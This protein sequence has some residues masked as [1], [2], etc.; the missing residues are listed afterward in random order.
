MNAIN[1]YYGTADA[2][3]VKKIVEDIALAD[4]GRINIVEERAGRRPRG[5]RT[6]S[7]EAPIITLVNTTFIDAI[8]KGACDVHFEPYE[9]QFRIR[10]RIDGDLYEMVSLPLKFRSPVLSRVKIL[11]NMDIAEKRLPQ[12]GRIK[13]RVKLENGKRKE[14]DMRV[15]SLPTLFGEKIVARILDKEMLKLDLTQ[16]G[17]EDES[18]ASSR[19]PS[20]G[21]GASSWSPGRREAARRTPSIRPSPP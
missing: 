3:K 17:F 21:P 1:K 16:L 2:L 14:V 7:E 12:D 19:T 5:D 18:L 4:E 11:S 9:Q 15:S 6:A 13:M 8:K 10:Y 20:S